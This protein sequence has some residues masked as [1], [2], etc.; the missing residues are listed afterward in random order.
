MKRMN[1]R[2]KYR[3]TLFYIAIGLWLPVAAHAA[4]S[5]MSAGQAGAGQLKRGMGNISQMGKKAKQDAGVT[6]LNAYGGIGNGYDQ[7]SGHF[8][9]QG[10]IM[11]KAGNTQYVGGIGIKITSCN[12]T[13][14]QVSSA[15]VAICTSLRKNGTPCTSRSYT[16]KGTAT[17]GTPLSLGKATL[18]LNCQ[19]LDCGI[20]LTYNGS[21]SAS[22]PNIKTQAKQAAKAVGSSGIVS[23]LSNTI[24]GQA[25]Q[26]DLSKEGPTGTCFNNQVGQLN[27]KGTISNCAGTY[28][29]KMI[30]P[31]GSQ[32]Q[33]GGASHWQQSCSTGL[34]VNV[35]S[36]HTTRECKFTQ[37]T[38]QV[39]CTTG[40]V[41]QLIFTEGQTCPYSFGVWCSSQMGSTVYNTTHNAITNGY[42]KMFANGGY[43]TTWNSVPSTYAFCNYAGL[44]CT[45]VYSCHFSYGRKSCGYR[46]VCNYNY[47]RATQISFCG[48]QNCSSITKVV[49]SGGIVGYKCDN[50]GST[51]CP[52]G[53]T[54]STS[55]STTTCTENVNVP[56]SCT[57]VG[58]KT[59][60]VSGASS[61]YEKIWN[62]NTCGA[63]QSVSP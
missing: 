20:N 39:S 56:K 53:F 18:T 16:K 63:Y 23:K 3:L 54:K 44:G 46:T 32:C 59:M 55:G 51:S 2:Q 35:S 52:S 14:N 10:H 57:Y 40:Q 42:T 1:L 25:L 60:S 6:N 21:M 43:V 45:Q 11:C 31:V 62:C 19:G 24:N 33:H 27:S 9:A 61:A 58:T 48:T 49:S 12:G 30:Q 22:G 7:A 17:P 34:N 28:T 4:L 13:N 29:L 50:S 26:S 5:P 41:T 37:Q 15:G 47:G 36:C 8:T 38:Q